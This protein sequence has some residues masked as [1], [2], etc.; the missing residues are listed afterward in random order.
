MIVLRDF[1]ISLYSLIE[2]YSMSYYWVWER[3]WDL[4]RL[5]EGWGVEDELDGVRDGLRWPLRQFYS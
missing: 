3:K 5:I 2:A 4:F 1:Y